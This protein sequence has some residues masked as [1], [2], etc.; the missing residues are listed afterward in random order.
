MRRHPLDGPFALTLR[1]SNTERLY[2]LSESAEAQGL[3]RGMGLSDARAL[4]PSLQTLTAQPEGDVRFLHL[5]AR[6]AGRY[7]PWVGLEGKAGLV[8]DVTGST[9]LFGGEQALLEALQD[10]MVRAGLTVHLA[11]AD[12]RGAAWALARFASD[13]PLAVRLVETGKGLDALGNLSVAALRLDDKTC[14][15]LLRLGV[16]TIA[17]LVALPRS[18][19]TRRFGQEP[20]LRLDQALGDRAEAIS[21]LSEPL[22][23]GVRMSLPEPIGLTS[24]V[25]AV[26]ERLLGRLCDKLK[27]QGVGARVLQLTVRRM[28]QVNQQV[29][30]RLARPMREAER[31]LPLFE[32]GVG[33]LDAGFGIDMIRLE[34]TAI[35]ALFDEQT[36]ASVIYDLK[37]QGNSKDI[38]HSSGLDDLVTRLGNRI[39]LENV[40]RF[41]PADSHIPERSFSI[42][43][44]AWSEAVS[45]WPPSPPR[46]MR[47][48]TPE[49]IV[50]SGPD[51]VEQGRREPPPFFRWRR[52]ALTL[53]AWRGPERIMPEWWWEDADWRAGMRDYWRVET[54]QGWRLWL[55]HT[56]QNPV[57]HLSSW[58]VQGVFA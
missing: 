48:F 1:Q 41:V 19:V 2:C 14:T 33:D 39:G 55:F 18:T 40:T 4:C 44:V 36:K 24:D 25:M 5:L 50:I 17:D 38:S 47:L 31:I 29:E 9:H 43:P 20:L 46:P 58:F 22:H 30:L 32:R 56:P 57:P 3:Q 35:D 12:T 51:P 28:D 13:L 8:M 6:W 10:R 37:E 7:C 54:R 21:P 11:M 23:Y 53:E 34:A 49:P 42:Q 45:H 52:M 15:G 16:R 26:A 27:K